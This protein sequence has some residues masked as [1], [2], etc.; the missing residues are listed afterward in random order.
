MATYLKKA[1]DNLKVDLNVSYGTKSFS[2]SITKTFS[3]EIY[4]EKK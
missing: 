4:Q 3:E 1:G 2:K